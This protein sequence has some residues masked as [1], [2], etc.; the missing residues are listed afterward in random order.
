MVL[1]FRILAMF[2]H[3]EDETTAVVSSA[4]AL[5][6][7]GRFKARDTQSAGVV[8]KLRDENYTLAF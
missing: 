8:C 6:V 3:G 4:T 7:A 5:V 2:R 1:P